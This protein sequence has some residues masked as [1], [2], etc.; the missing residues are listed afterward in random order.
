MGKLIITG[1]QKI[2]G[3]ISV[4]GSKNA[5]LPILA[6]T[7][8]ND[9]I[10]VIKNCPRLRDVERMIE[11][12]RKIGCKVSFEKGVV[13]VDSSTINS[14]EVPEDLAV[15]MR[16]SIIFLGPIL[17]RFK[18]VTISYPGDWVTL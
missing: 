18:K 1:G 10:S 12:L 13:T 7:V 8:L 11:I 9:G 17:S 5:V 16:S 6:A 4:E 15:E 14:T 2:K 3:A